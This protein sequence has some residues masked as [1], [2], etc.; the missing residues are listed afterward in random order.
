MKR[1]RK[2]TAL[3]LAL[4]LLMTCL[5][6]CSG[7][8]ADSREGRKEGDKKATSTPTQKPDDKKPDNSKKDDD[9]T[10]SATPTPEKK[11]IVMW[12]NATTS[13]Y[14]RHAYV[15]AA[16]EMEKL[17]P[18]VDFRWEA[19][20]LGAYQLK[21]KTAV[22]G[23]ALPDFFYVDTSS[24][25]EL[26]LNDKVY[27]LD[28]A[29][30]K[31]ASDLPE[32][33]CR[34]FTYDGHL[35]GIP[36]TFDCAV[37]F[38]NLDMLKQVGYTEIPVSYD[39]FLVC[40]NRLKEAG[41]TPIAC[42]GREAWCVSLYLESMMLKYVGPETLDRVFKGEETWNNKDFVFVAAE[43]QDIMLGKLYAGPNMSEISDYEVRCGFIDGEY[44]FYLNGTWDCAELMKK[45]GFEIAVGEFP[46]LS[47]SR[48]SKGMMIGGPDKALAVSKNTA[49]VEFTAEF[50]MKFAH[51]VS[52][53][54]YQE[55]A[56]L[57][58]WRINYDESMLNPLFR[59]A[60]SMAQQANAMVIFGDCC[61]NEEEMHWYHEAIKHLITGS[62]NGSGFI[63]ELS[64]NIR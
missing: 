11:R 37:M 6:A 64:T 13:D 44:A 63:T 53:Y 49:D 23:N 2:M 31:C 20:E 4:I 51:L 8:D 47:Y 1:F 50:A 45:A 14:E 62:D 5:S 24:L 43:L 17:Y 55:G 12:C 59:Q 15:R 21:V 42:S 9:Q 46:I 38:A 57:P 3:C 41:Y 25:K 19:L 36:T 18:N 52:Q 28:S 35:Y 30:S 33:M 32:V 16:A 54:S 29:Y 34:N 61:M 27:C 60:A 39:E 7:S 40:C 58:A 22:A 48:A 26:V 56:R 10:P